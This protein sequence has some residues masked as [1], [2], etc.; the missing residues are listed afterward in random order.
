LLFRIC[1]WTFICTVH[2]IITFAFIN[3]HLDIRRII[4]IIT[5]AV[6]SALKIRLQQKRKRSSF[7]ASLC[8]KRREGVFAFGS[9]ML[10]SFT[11]KHF[12]HLWE[13]R[14]ILQGTDKIH[15][16]KF[17]Y[18]YKSYYKKFLELFLQSSIQASSVL[19]ELPLRHSHPLKLRRH[20]LTL[21]ASASA[22]S[23]YTN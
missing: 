9:K 2:Y 15:Q 22:S 5:Q 14:N 1:V 10:I 18:I 7:Y 17:N 23:S 6:A 11:P 16:V 19:I 12:I 13:G 8:T 4:I 21:Q 20:L 3:I